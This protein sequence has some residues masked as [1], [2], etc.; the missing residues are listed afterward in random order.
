MASST[1]TSLCD[2]IYTMLLDK[3][4]M[5]AREIA[6]R[7]SQSGDPTTR[8]AVNS[9]LYRNEKRFFARDASQRPKWRSLSRPRTASA[10]GNQLYFW[11]KQA[12]DAWVDQGRRGVIE[13]VTGTGK[14][15]V[16]LEAIADAVK[17][18]GYANVLVPS[19]DPQRQWVKQLRSRFPGL[20][21]GRRGNAHSDSFPQCQVLVSV[22]NSAREYDPRIVSAASLLVADECHRYGAMANAKALSKTFQRRLGL[23]ATFAREDN[24]CDEYLS[25]YFGDTCF[26]MG[27]RQAIQDE[28]TA[29][30]KVALVGVGFGS[31]QER[32]AYQD[33]TRERGKARFWLTENEWVPQDPFG[34][35]MKHVA[36][37][38]DEN[39]LCT[40]A[41]NYYT[42]VSKARD[43]LR[44][45]TMCRKMLAN[46]ASKT[47]KLGQLVDAIKNADRT[48]V[49]TESIDAANTAST[50]LT[51]DG[52]FCGSIHS[53]LSKADRS[54]ILDAF[55]DGRLPAIVAPKVLD[56]G[57]DVPA[58]DLAI[59]FATSKSRRQMVQRMGRVLRR[60]HDGR[61]ARFV[62]FYVE[63]S[64]EDPETGA[65]ET[66]LNEIADPSVADVVRAFHSTAPIKTILDYLNDFDVPGGQ[67]PARLAPLP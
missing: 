1:R 3:P 58:A 67:P 49:F 13:A 65:H 51:E 16:G 23:T 20:P 42:A 61:L 44:S 57:I 26:Q 40:G 47:R 55:S 19:I 35:F 15:R 38:A 18:G 9:V 45:F 4:N 2:T 14:T 21:I 37:L 63:G 50:C 29:H 33:A 10:S 27:Y 48:I 60:K 30:F 66:F 12:Y 36:K 11:Q 6:W 41:G 64:S 17:D 5:T 43:Y 32:S 54:Q 31:E 53:N 39:E 8:H 62:V 25:P 46:T 34:E 28:V 52:V 22:V 59:I 7:L 24:G 56:E